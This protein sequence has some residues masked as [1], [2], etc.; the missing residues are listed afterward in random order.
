MKTTNL[1]GMLVFVS[2]VLGACGTPAAT[3]TA[4][5]PT[6]EATMIPLQPATPTAGIAPLTMPMLRNMQYSLPF[7]N[8]TVSLTDGSYQE[9]AGGNSYSVILLDNTMAFGDL[10]G[11]GVADAVAVV[12]EN[13]GG[14]GEFESLIAILDQ[15]GTPAQVSAAQ[16][17]DR[18]QINA[19]S[20]QDGQVMLQML[21]QG[22][23]DPMC[24]PS[25]PVTETYVLSNGNLVLVHLTS[26]TAD[27]TKRIIQIES[28]AAGTQVADTVE[29][30]GS[31]SVAPFENTL[32]YRLYDVTD[33]QLAEGSLTVDAT[34]TG[35]TFD[36]T[37]D[38]SPVPTGTAFRLVLLDISAADGTTLALDSVD[39]SRK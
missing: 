9:G 34:G 28:P 2:L 33:N 35:G 10:D 21:V 22:P 3:A 16:L 31:M 11:D 25:L 37:I 8:R 36:A 23:N 1:F 18:V 38:V 12:S 14:S 39:L 15:A 5:P 19:V 13:G 6:P 29:V 27:G 32:G 20:I 30:K 24:C 17:G 4:L 26:E 7:Y